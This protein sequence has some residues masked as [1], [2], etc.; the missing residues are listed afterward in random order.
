MGPEFV[1][2]SFRTVSRFN[3][4]EKEMDRKELERGVVSHTCYPSTREA[5]AEDCKIEAQ[6][7]L[8]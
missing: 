1:M 3:H 6:S 8:T 7:G 4:L 5:E 2:M